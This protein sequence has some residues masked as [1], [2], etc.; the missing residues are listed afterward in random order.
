MIDYVIHKNT[1]IFGTV[2]HIITTDGMGHL[3]ATIEDDDIETIFFCSLSVMPE[4]RGNG[5]GRSL[6]KG[7]ESLGKQ[8]R[9]KRF[10][11]N[12]EKSD[13]GLVSYYEKLG[14]EY[15]DE[16]KDYIYLVKYNE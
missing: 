16:D 7:G 14:Y 8:F 2:W 12:V 6:I 5:I 11:L 4:V 3:E 10:R 9:V 1:T 15:L 13:I